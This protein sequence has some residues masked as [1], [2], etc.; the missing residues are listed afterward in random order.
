MLRKYQVHMRL[1]KEMDK[2]VEAGSEGSWKD[3]LTQAKD[4]QELKVSSP[5]H[6]L[7]NFIAFCDII[8]YTEMFVLYTLYVNFEPYK[9]MQ[10][11]HKKTT[12]IKRITNQ[13]LCVVPNTYCCSFAVMTITL[14]EKFTIAEKYFA[15]LEILH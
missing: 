10:S 12:K 3:L 8:R 9:H 15:P 13:L 14:A 1:M 7:S 6:Q 11:V 2:I 5:R 4:K